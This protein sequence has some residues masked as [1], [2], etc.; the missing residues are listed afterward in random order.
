MK[1]F[2]PSL[3]ILFITV[4]FVGCD[5]FTI[6]GG[7]GFA[8]DSSDLV[9]EDF[10]NEIVETVER[11]D[12]IV[13]YMSDNFFMSARVRLR[14]IEIW[15]ELEDLYAQSEHLLHSRGIGGMEIAYYSS[16]GIIHAEIV[17]QYEIY[18][19]II[20]AH[21][22]GTDAYLT[23]Y[24]KEVYEKAQQILRDNVRETKW[25]TIHALH[26]YL[27]ANIEFEHNHE[28]NR[29]A[30][31]VYGAL[32]EGRAVCQ[33][34]AHSFRL[35]LHLA[36]VENL[37]VTGRAGNEY[38]AW[39]LVNFGESSGS[40]QWYHVDVT[41]NDR[42]DATSNRYFAV[43]DRVL[44]RTHTWQ[45]NYFPVAVSMQKNYF[46]F[47]GKTA[48]TQGELEQLFQNAIGHGEYFIEIL[49]EFPVTAHDLGFIWQHGHLEAR[50]SI[51]PYGNDFMLTIMLDRAEGSG[52]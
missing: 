1:R 11:L 46:R 43:S 45:R 34:Y 28:N 14:S 24:S 48:S 23:R 37:I 50:Q 42:D 19:N 13:A 49:C 8:T 18:M 2:L 47:T 25:E 30:F 15:E 52:S 4:A 39:N 26:E 38:H 10:R 31:D 20:I 16:G 21:E 17:P 29:G 6:G 51:E 27:R 3:L 35:L 7:G 36:G 9:L 5:W 32:I 40:A 33:G 12:E 41:W 22:R 44:E